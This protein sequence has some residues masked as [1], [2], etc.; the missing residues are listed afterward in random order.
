VREYLRAPCCCPGTRQWL[1]VVL[2]L[3]LFARLRTQSIRA[4]RPPELRLVCL[5]P[6]QL[7][8]GWLCLPRWL[9]LLERW[10]RWELQSGV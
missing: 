5:P 9:S 3:L 1:L 4:P 6:R 8:V 2:L 7:L 10:E